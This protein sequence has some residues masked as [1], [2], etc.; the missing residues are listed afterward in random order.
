MG[1]FKNDK[2]TIK[3]E[4]ALLAISVIALVIGVVL[5]VTKPEVWFISQANFVTLGAL[6]ILFFVMMIPSVLYRFMT[7]DI[8]TKKE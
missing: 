3:D 7:N 8:K 6:L 1:I 5:I 2:T 4:I